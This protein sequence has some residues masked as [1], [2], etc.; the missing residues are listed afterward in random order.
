MRI[1]LLTYHHSVNNGA[2]LQTYAT[3]KALKQLGHDVFIVD[4]RQPEK[5]RGGIA[6]LVIKCL[7]FQ[8]DREVMSYKRHFYPELTRTYTSVEDLR[9]DPPQADCY[10]V[11][12]DQTWNPAKSK[13]M[14][15]AYFLAFGADGIKRVSYASSLG[16]KKWGGE[17][18]FTEEIKVALEKF[19][20]I[21]VREKS[22]QK[23]LKETFGIN[24][25]LVVDP[26]LL[27]D[28]YP[29]LANNVKEKNE[30]IC[31]KLRRNRDFY[32][33]IGEL[34]QA[35]GCPARLINN[36][37]PVKGLRYTTP[38]G[39][40]GWI[41]LIAS[42]KFV[43]T[44]SFHGLAFSLLNKRQFAVVRILDGEDSRTEDLLASLGLEDRIFDSMTDMLDSRCFEKKIDYQ[45]ISERMQNLREASWD[46]L[47][48]AVGENKR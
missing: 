48:E 33:H 10:L 3:V 34:K 25:T 2:M 20:A 40:A 44:D 11:G 39:P 14:M 41:K 32:S 26:T 37:Y 19:Q 31:Y 16:V 23:V 27:F 17:P 9:N 21:S 12:S 46:F 13:N 45:V 8:R 5:Q 7:Y 43:I 15:M 22:G 35:L 30:I 29:E 28:G 6:G 18:S 38:H 42:A 4:I 47:R 1:G 36:A 24:S